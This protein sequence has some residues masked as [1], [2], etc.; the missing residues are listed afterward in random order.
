MDDLYNNLKI[1]ETE[2]KGSSS[3]NQ[4][5]QNVAFVSSNNSGSSNQAHG[6]NSAN[7]DSMSDVIDADDLE[8][9]DLKWQMAMLTMRARR[10]LNKTRRKISVNGSK[11]IGFNK[12][13]VECYNCHKRG[14]FAR[15]CRAPRENRNREPVRRNVTVETTETKAL[16]AQD[17]LGYDWSDQ[18]EEGP[19]NLQL[20]QKYTQ[21]QLNV[22]PHKVGLESVEARLDV[23][24]KN[25]VVFEEDIKILKLDIMLKDNALTELRKKFEKAEKERDDLKRTLEKFENSSKNLSK[26]LEIQVNVNKY[27]TVERYHAVP[28]SPITRN[29]NPLKPEPLIEDWISDSEDE[30]KTEFKESVEKVENNKQAKYPRKNS[31]I[32]RDCDFYEKKMAEK[33]VWNNA[34]RLNHQNSQ[35]LTHPHSKGNFVPRAVLMKSGLK[36]LNTAR[37]N[38]SRAAVNTARPINTAYPRPIVNCARPASNVFNRAHSHVRRPFNK[39][40]TNKNSN[41]NEKVNTVRGN[42]TTVGPKAVVS[43]NKGNEANAVKASACWVWRPKQKVLDHG[44]PQLELQEKGVID[45]GCSRH[46]TGNK[47]Y[48]SDYEEIDGGFVAFGGN[49]KGGK[50]TGKGK[51]RIGKL[52]FEDVYFVKEL[53]F[54]LFSVSQMCDKKNSVL[55]TDTECVVLSPDFKLLDESQVLLRVPRKNNMYS[56]DLKNV[57]PSG[58]LTCLFAK[59]TLDESNL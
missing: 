15:E 49:P 30:N 46:M 36:T 32:P 33:P 35:R 12:S 39:F 38:S 55:F 48:L 44:N 51:I 24:K 27:K 17:G 26:L 50:I 57:V 16:V 47:S 52:D 14:H 58:G 18:A 1:Y 25:E 6:S 9:M 34:R 37:Q 5:S 22:G 43:D 4:N 41:F 53:K 40:T 42:V 59:G 45:S 31:Q 28:T 20:C 13:K 10:F 8:E 54:N 7:T 3:S 23:Y 29:F 11:T 56:V 21:S 19:T 2:V